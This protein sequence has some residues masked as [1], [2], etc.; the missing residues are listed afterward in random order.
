MDRLLVTC[1]DDNPG[2]ARTIEKNGG[3]LEDV[4][5]TELGP[6]RRYWISL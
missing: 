2:S 3:V 6:T 4:R 5:A 1:R